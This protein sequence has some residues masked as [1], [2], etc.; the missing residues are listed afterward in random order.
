MEATEATRIVLPGTPD[1][2]AARTARWWGAAAR[3]RQRSR[4]GRGL[5]GPRA[6]C[7]PGPAKLLW[8]HGLAEFIDARSQAE[9]AE[10]H[11]PRSHAID[12]KD[13]YG[14]RVPRAID[15]LDPEGSS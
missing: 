4:A 9:H 10:G 15:F 3:S 12:P 7:D 1:A 11:I 13:L 5:A 6:V 8:E 14:G 2:E